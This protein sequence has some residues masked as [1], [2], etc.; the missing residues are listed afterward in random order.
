MAIDNVIP[1]AA[2]IFCEGGLV[3]PLDVGGTWEVVLV[4]ALGGDNFQGRD[5]LS[6]GRLRLWCGSG[7]FWFRFRFRS[8]GG[9]RRWRV[10][11]Y[12]AC[13]AGYVYALLLTAGPCALRERGR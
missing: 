11:S 4:P 12:P 3:A 2:E 5:G 13:T 6:R 10:G 9:S 8:G 1:L 7:R